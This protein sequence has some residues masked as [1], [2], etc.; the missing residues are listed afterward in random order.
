MRARSLSLITGC[1]CGIISAVCFVLSWRIRKWVLAELYPA[2]PPDLS[3][4]SSLLSAPWC[5]LSHRLGA[6]QSTV[7]TAL[8]QLHIFTGPHHHHTVTSRDTANIVS[9][10]YNKIY[11]NPPPPHHNHHIQMNYQ[12]PGQAS[13]SVTGAL[14]LPTQECSLLNIFVSMFLTSEP[15]HYSSNWWWWL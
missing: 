2:S 13:A 1:H 8:C 10:K 5:R 12:R 9:W 4:L 3:P 14:C 6:E 11:S 15:H 7:N